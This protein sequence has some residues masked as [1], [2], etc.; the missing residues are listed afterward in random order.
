MFNEFHSHISSLPCESIQQ[1]IDGR[2]AMNVNKCKISSIIIVSL[3]LIGF[4]L[5]LLDVSLLYFKFVTYGQIQIK[6]PVEISPPRLS[7]CFRY[8]DL[9]DFNRV[10]NDPRFDGKNFKLPLDKLSNESIY[11][12]SY[13]NVSDIFEFTPNITSFFGESKRY[14]YDTD[15]VSCVYRHPRSFIAE[16]K[17]KEECEK[18]FKV[19]K[20]IQREFICYFLYIWEDADKLYDITHVSF[21]KYFFGLMYHIYL[22]IE[23]FKNAHY[24]TIF[25][26]ERESHRLYDST[27]TNVM[28]RGFSNGNISRGE[29][30]RTS[31]YT[32][33]IERLSA[34]YDTNCINVSQKYQTIHTDSAGVT[35]DCINNLVLN[36]T[37]KISHLGQITEKYNKTLA[38]FSTLEDV[39]IYE[40]ALNRCG[41]HF[42]SCK[43]KTVSTKTTL[44]PSNFFSVSV[45]WPQD[46]INHV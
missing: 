45:F 36:E 34:P 2:L 24:F 30:I 43:F 17:S 13:F 9:I 32:S 38:P 16:L 15:S 3:C 21:S 39:E 27:L 40:R 18:L 33:E 23:T 42:N 22:N 41:I 46:A 14:Y 26:H 4:V 8:R 19:K 6:I 1:N 35:F 37:D 44:L 7:L 20:Y 25:V 29:N 10:S 12:E 5:Q 11:M 31:Y 28:S